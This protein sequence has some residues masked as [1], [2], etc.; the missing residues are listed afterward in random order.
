M[1]T[2]NNIIPCMATPPGSILKYELD[3]RG[4]S[5]KDFA[6]MVG[7]QK[8]HLNELL[9]G[10]RP[11]TKKM[12]D[13]IESALGISAVSLINLQTQ[14]DYDSRMIA[15]QKGDE[16]K[17][18]TLLQVYNEFLD[19]DILFHR[20]KNEANT[21]LQKVH[22]LVENMHIPEPSM[23]KT[24]VQ[25]MYKKTAKT[26]V[27]SR[28]LMTWRMLAENR[29][30]QSQSIGK[31]NKSEGK[32]LLNAL[33][34]IL[35]KNENTVEK[36]QRILSENGIIFCIEPQVNKIPID[37]Y[38]FMMNGTPYL[39]L[40]A[41]YNQIDSFAFS[42]MHELGHIYLHYQ[43]DNLKGKLN[44][45]DGANESREE[46]M[47]NKFA[48]Q[49]LVPNSEWKTSPQVPMDPVAIQ[50]EYTRWAE[51][52]DLNKWIVLGRIAYETGMYKFRQDKSRE[53]R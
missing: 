11:M 49:S 8:S 36:V 38:S 12:A 37:G 41:R 24:E 26:D 32:K 20:I 10:K 52:N 44:I 33:F 15:A 14:Y 30:L 53:I 31:F 19:I 50:R 17:A 39:V 27:D 13:K 40:T 6:E 47:A 4:I 25:K 34:L 45:A 43:E 29:A 46:R 28:L 3:E 1:A 48:T 51:Q 2:K 18:L 22:F 23:L 7:M 5:Q 42:L 21:P 35:H 9:K 16:Q